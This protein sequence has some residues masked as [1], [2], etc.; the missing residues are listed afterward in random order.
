M[1]GRE[2]VLEAGTRKALQAESLQEAPVPEGGDLGTRGFSPH[3]ELYFRYTFLPMVEGSQ[4]FSTQ[5]THFVRS[6]SFYL[7]G[8]VREEEPRPR[9][10]GLRGR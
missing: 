6:H 7:S 9:L 5:E 1:P 3:Q 2:Q 10:L 4:A 8:R